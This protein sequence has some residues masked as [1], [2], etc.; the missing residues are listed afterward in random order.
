MS[1]WFSC[2]SDFLF[3]FHRN[4]RNIT[5]LATAFMANSLQS[6]IDEI[7]MKK[8]FTFAC[9]HA[10]ICSREVGKHIQIGGRKLIMYLS[11]KLAYQC[12]MT[13]KYLIAL[14]RNCNQS[15]LL[16]IGKKILFKKIS[17]HC[18]R[19]L[20]CCDLFMDFLQTEGKTRLPW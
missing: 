19:F 5:F 17:L 12:Y 7:L 20:S 6:V 13:S 3:T 2:T 16:R 10:G 1:N 8:K 9:V 15:K 18:K 11:D 14:Q 4:S